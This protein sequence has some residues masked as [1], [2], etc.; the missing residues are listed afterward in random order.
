MSAARPLGPD[1]GLLARSLRFV[2][3]N[4]LVVFLLTTLLAVQGVLVAPFDWEVAGLP[5]DPIPVDAIPDTGDNQQ[6]VF[7]N[8]P[9]R[10]PQDVEDQITYPLTVA[11][12]GVP[13]VKSIRSS[14][15]FGFSM[16]YVIFNEDV[17]FYW[18]RSRLLEKL[19]SLPDGTLPEGVQPALGPDA[20][21]LGQVFWY[22]LEGR[23]PDGQAVGGWDLH[24]LRSTQ[25]WHVRYALAAVEGVAE[26]ASI[27]GHVQEYQIDVDPD[28]MRAHGVT[29]DQ[30]FR[31]VKASNVDVGART[32]EVNRVEYVV[33]GLGLLESIEDIEDTV[34][35]VRDNVPITIRQ[36]ASVATGPALRRGVL[37]KGGTEAVGGV[38]VVRYGANPLAVIERVK[39]R[40]AEIAP[41]LPTKTLDD[42]T[43]SRITVVPFYD[44]TDLIFETLGTLRE[45]LELEILVTVLVVLVMLANVRSAAL[46]AGLLPL[47]VLFCFV[48]MKHFGVDAN[49]VALSGIAI[50]IGTMVD[51]GIVVTE[52]IVAKL[53][54]RD[55]AKERFRKVL[56]ATTEVGG[57]VMT[58]VAT[59]VISFLP[60]FT[61]EGPEGKLF[62]PLAF[63]KTY[64]LV[65]SILV[66]LLVLPPVAVLLLRGSA[67]RRD[68]AEGR[69]SR[70]VD[71]SGSRLR[72]RIKRA[73]R[74]ALVLALAFGLAR[75]WE[76]LGAE[77][78]FANLAFTA[79]AVFGALAFFQLL[80]WFYEPILRW[81][82]AH[83]LA[84]LSLPAL[85]M[86]LGL[87]SWLGF[88]R[89]GAPVADAV[90]FTGW[91]LRTTAVWK[92]AMH[93]FP[94]LG[95]EF[96]PPLDE[97]SFL[98]MPVT[99]AHASIGESLDMLQQQD[100]R[101]RSIPE[102][103]D[104]VGKI[105]RVESALDPAPVSMVE[106]II[107]YVPEY[108]SDA[109]GHR[110]RFAYDEARDE[111]VRG[112]DG[113]LVPDDDGRVFRQWRDRIESPLDIWKE[114]EHA[115]QVPGMTTASML[116]PIETRRIM[117]QTGMRAAMGIKVQGP[118][119]KTIEG[120]A[121][122]LEGLLREVPSVRPE[123]VLA[124]RL[125][126]KPYLEIDIDRSAIAR[127]GLSV[128]N[129]QDVIEVAIGGRRLT[130]TVEGRERYP[131]RVRYQRELRN[132]IDEL[133]RIIVPAADGSQIPLGQ[134]TDIRYTPGPQNLKSE[135]TFLVAHVLFDRRPGFAE[136]DVV[137]DC[138]AHVQN[139][140][141]TGRFQLPAGVSYRFAGNWEN[142]V[143][144]E[145]KLRLVLPLSL[146]LIFMILWLCFRSTA[147]TL[148]VFS[149][150]FV[151][152]SGGF[153]LLWLYGQD[154]FL[155][156]TLLG[157]N[158]RDVFAVGP[159]NLSVAVWVGFLALFG[160]ATDDGVVLAT[161]IKQT[162][163]HDRPTTKAEVREA[164]VRAGLRRIRPCL[165]TTATTA[166]A[167]L[168]VLS[169]TGR[170]SDVMVPMAIPSFGGMLVATV[171]IFVVPTLTSW[172][173]E[174]R[175]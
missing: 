99:M 16:V 8:W 14:S 50:A 150:V 97:G 71:A 66:G 144:A 10:S 119:L 58:A 9:G 125:I 175:L 51:V 152:W 161:Y 83:K 63:T 133:Q 173:Q 124:D 95:K 73:G 19:S 171:T 20:T 22:T 67:R 149:A 82:L 94:G 69:A 89:V 138:I 79:L 98:L 76:P 80:L 77:R 128:M 75:L 5:R 40:L 163:E 12:L 121:L 46:I 26:V 62:R 60:V 93:V 106:T 81:C 109:S 169:S 101:I 18:S 27:G 141:E 165:M 108:K 72:G 143:R 32:I 151:A 86:V 117:L 49:I 24:E 96:M 30:V 44:R 129:V 104:V 64:A 4:K 142:Q 112:P 42:G 113:L 105:G 156:T 38:V 168:P 159:V 103:Q 31:A 61:M 55:T 78:V 157:A 7:T 87:C 54:A 88:E 154:W 134:L 170:G 84:F 41:G 74:F 110:L 90:G 100:R 123:T 48:A 115:G 37:D 15:M 39:Q 139:A 2:L 91:D 3:E 114:I 25:D 57:A 132:E 116:Q 158:L 56:R 136:V 160:I 59:T 140:L 65:A 68:E 1:E 167:L 28:A 166:L 35:D 147:L 126:G 6:I 17:E 146:L 164:I 43:V 13:S 33:R 122:E 92:R 148:I 135:D 111:F 118:D 23:A 153:L 155:D 102:V 34:V 36:I 52:S 21:A 162:L 29:L 53:E 70:A 137:E 107:T 172:I 45:A 130:T 85:T 11:L 127:H 131:V 47:A 174:R 145:Q 120:V